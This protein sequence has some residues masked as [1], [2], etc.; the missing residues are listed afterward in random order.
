MGRTFPCHPFAGQLYDCEIEAGVSDDPYPPPNQDSL[1][2]K[3]ASVGLATASLALGICSLFMCLLTGIP[4][5]ICGHIAR[6][7]IKASG[8]RL[9]GSGK[10]LAGLILGYLSIVAIPVV[11]ILA[12]LAVPVVMKAQQKAEEVV[13][14]QELGTL[15]K[16]LDLYAVEHEGNYPTHLSELLPHYLSAEELALLGNNEYGELIYVP[17]LQ[18]TSPTDAVILYQRF[19]QSFLIARLDNSVGS[20]S[21]ED[22]Q[23]VAI[24]QG[25]AEPPASPAIR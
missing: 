18:Q 11:I 3:P 5:I 20:L 14:I 16:T 19:A 12:G 6:S 21:E 1:A 15:K 7:R 23:E 24:R 25:L 17:D 13:R 10:A 22:F 8:G 4:A 9:G 2:T